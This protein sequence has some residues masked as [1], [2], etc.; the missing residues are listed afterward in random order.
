MRELKGLYALWLRELIV[1][2]RERSRVISSLFTPI[3]W[4]VV[5][6]S[7]MGASF[8]VGAVNYQTFLFPGI[9]GMSALFTSVFFGLYIIWDKKIDFFKEVIVAPLSR[10][11]IFTGKMLGGC[12]D[13]LLQGFLLFLFAGFF[14]IPYNFISIGG[15]LLFL[16]L[17]STVLVSFGLTLGALLDSFEGFNLISSFLIFPMF[18]FSGALFPLQNLPGWLTFFIYIDPLTYAVDGMRGVMLGLNKFP[19][20]IDILILAGFSLVS[21]LMGTSAFRRLR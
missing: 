20:G 12:T 2:T 5:F 21:I 18:F 14:G 19:L 8:N 10:V 16:F 3:L 7:G 6:G 11:T 13:A 9:L 1:F 17:V 4:L 15:T